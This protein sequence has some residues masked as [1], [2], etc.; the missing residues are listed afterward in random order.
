MSLTRLR[1]C[2]GVGELTDLSPAPTTDLK[3]IVK[4]SQ[5]AMYVFTD[6][7]LKYSRGNALAA[8]IKA[9]NLS[10][11]FFESDSLKNPNSGNKI[12]LWQFVPDWE[13]IYALPLWSGVFN[14]EDK[15]KVERLDNLTF[16][17][18]KRI[19]DKKY[20]AVNQRYG[21]VT[22]TEDMI[23]KLTE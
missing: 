7:D 9:N 11:K 2:C 20:L 23:T 13:K 15:V 8:Y 16:R 21:T 1:S 6:V 12:K 14:P 3:Q 17:I 22:V 18:I 5:Y 4:E 19:D 10:V